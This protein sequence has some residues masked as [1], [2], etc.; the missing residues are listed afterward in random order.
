MELKNQIL[1]IADAV[2]RNGHVYTQAALEKAVANAQERIKNQNGILGVLGEPSHAGMVNLAEISHA[3]TN[4]RM[5]GDKM[6]ADLK[7]LETPRGLQLKK[8]IEAGHGPQFNVSGYG[9]V[10]NDGKVS[11]FELVTVYATNSLV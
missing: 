9:S 8:M 1:K 6:V 5:D 10:S 4:L 7:I 2:Q 11:D 3:V